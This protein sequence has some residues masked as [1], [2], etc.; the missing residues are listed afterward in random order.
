MS[1]PSKGFYGNLLNSSGTP[2][3][4]LEE[5][6]SICG[7]GDGGGRHRSEGVSWKFSLPA[8]LCRILPFLQALKVLGSQGTREN[9]G[10]RD[11][12]QLQ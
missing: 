1:V 12:G 9:S 2:S 10:W 5:L 3:P 4:T 6:E 8:Q 7:G 11:E